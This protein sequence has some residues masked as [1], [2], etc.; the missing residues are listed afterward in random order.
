MISIPK[1]DM[2]ILRV[3]LQEGKTIAETA[4]ICNTSA[5]TVRRRVVKYKD[6]YT[7]LIGKEYANADGHSDDVKVVGVNKD[8]VQKDEINSEYENTFKQIEEVVEAAEE[9][10]ELTESACTEPVQALVTSEVIMCVDSEGVAKQYPKDHPQ[11]EE[12]KNAIADQDWQK[13]HGII[14]FVENLKKYNF[15]F[16]EVTSRTVKFKGEG[17]TG[18]FAE[19]LMACVQRGEKPVALMK[20]FSNL[21]ENPSAISVESAIRFITHNNLPITDEGHVLT[22]KVVRN[23]YK[24]KHSGKFDNSVGQIVAMDRDDVTLDPSE[25]C[26]SGLHVC[27]FGYI[28]SFRSSDSR[29]M[30]AKVE[31]RHI[32]SVPHDYNNSKVR[33]CQYEIVGEL[34]N[35]ERIPGDMVSSE[36]DWY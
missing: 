7:A 3:R 36:C 18:K 28:N 2:E 8:A 4:K 27:S 23:D 15:G 24:D 16:F 30:I 26:A 29:I 12:L 6:A 22:Y 20:F 19:R 34:E 25:T 5:S 35:D 1:A 13:A 21:R 17:L 32:V 31:P 11:Y 10:G 33:A 14:N 9:I